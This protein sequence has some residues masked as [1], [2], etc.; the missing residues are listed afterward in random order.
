MISE[1]DMAKKLAEVATA[2]KAAYE[3]TQRADRLEAEWLQ[4]WENSLKGAE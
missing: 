3:A 4:W 2:R 1:K